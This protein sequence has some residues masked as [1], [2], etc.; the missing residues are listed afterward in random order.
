MIRDNKEFLNVTSMCSIKSEDNFKRSTRKSS[1]GGILTNNRDK[2][3]QVSQSQAQLPHQSSVKTLHKPPL[4]S[5]QRKLCGSP[6][7]ST[8]SGVIFQFN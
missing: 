5:V 8:K 7:Q 3:E 4:Q 2:K 1:V 6:D